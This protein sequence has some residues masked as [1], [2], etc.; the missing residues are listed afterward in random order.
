MLFYCLGDV[1]FLKTKNTICVARFFGQ[2][3]RDLTVLQALVESSDLRCGNINRTTQIGQIRVITSI[4]GKPL[5]ELL[6]LIMTTSRSRM[7]LSR[8]TD[9]E[10]VCHG[11]CCQN[12]IYKAYF[13]VWKDL[14]VVACNRIL[15]CYKKKLKNTQLKASLELIGRRNLDQEGH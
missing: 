14:P 13:C 6:S 3:L 10:I 7:G 8:C 1:E 12:S 4:R 11:Y 9:A 5:N 2:R 15:Q